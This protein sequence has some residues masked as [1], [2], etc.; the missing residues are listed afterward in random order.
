[1]S[2][3]QTKLNLNQQPNQNSGAILKQKFHKVNPVVSKSTMEKQ[4]D[5]FNM[6][7]SYKKSVLDFEDTIK[8]E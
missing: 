7:N 3:T 8:N 6:I 4:E 2:T 1:L 5:F